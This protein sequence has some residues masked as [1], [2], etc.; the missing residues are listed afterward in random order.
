VGSTAG[1][2]VDNRISAFAGECVYKLHV[3][4]KSN[5]K[6]LFLLNCLNYL[7]ARSCVSGQ[8]TELSVTGALKYDLNVLARQGEGLNTNIIAIAR[9]AVV[10]EAI[11]L[12]T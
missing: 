4:F 10:R 3:R 1:L 11:R 2:P 5:S 12:L 9:Q 8:N 6:F 7:T